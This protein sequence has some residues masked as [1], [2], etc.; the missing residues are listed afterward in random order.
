M[1]DECVLDSLVIAGLTRLRHF[2]PQPMERTG[3]GACSE[4]EL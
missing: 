2:D 4:E 3:V 1:A